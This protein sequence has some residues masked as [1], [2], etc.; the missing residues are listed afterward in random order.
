MLAIFPDN[1]LIKHGKQWVCNMIIYDHKK[2][3]N[4]LTP[5]I[6]RILELL[7]EGPKTDSELLDLDIPN[8]S[9]VIL[10]KLRDIGAIDHCDNLVYI[11]VQGEDLINRIDSN[12]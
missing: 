11:T 1:I 5:V 3:S 9:L 10:G 7:R 2:T 12:V 6:R 4:K 8:F